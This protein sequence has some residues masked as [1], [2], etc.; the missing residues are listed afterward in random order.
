MN[1]IKQF[2]QKIEDFLYDLY[3]FDKH[4]KKV[5]LFILIPV[6]SFGQGSLNLE[7]QSGTIEKVGDEF[8]LKIQYYV[9]DQGDATLIQF[10]YE[11]N[12]KLLELTNFSWAAPDG[13]STTRNQWTGYK[14]NDRP[15]TD[16]TDCLLYTSPSPRD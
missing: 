10:D 3:E 7:H 13:Y 4:M 11:Y 12:N 2:L 6:L 14:Y 15:D 8:T 1:K 9:G 5:I 16:A